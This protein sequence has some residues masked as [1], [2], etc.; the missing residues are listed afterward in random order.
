MGRNEFKE[1]DRYIGGDFASEAPRSTRDPW[2]LNGELEKHMS[3]LATTLVCSD[4]NQKLNLWP[5]T[6]KYIDDGLGGKSMII[7]LARGMASI[8]TIVGRQMFSEQLQLAQSLWETGVRPSLKYPG[9]IDDH[10]MTVCY[11]DWVLS[12]ECSM[13]VKGKL[14]YGEVE[15]DEHVRRL[16]LLSSP[17]LLNKNICVIQGAASIA[18]ESKPTVIPA[19]SKLTL[20]A[21][22]G[23]VRCLSK[24]ATQTQV[25]S[26]EAKSASGIRE[27]N[28]SAHPWHRPI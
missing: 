11:G 15:D 28:R 14:S 1:Q 24:I 26:V 16:L 4:P 21:A 22:E 17:G 5:V 6:L 25:T 12:I 23:P 10:D 2:S 9:G 7:M 18:A 13:K 3:C 19:G 20:Q 27:V 8:R